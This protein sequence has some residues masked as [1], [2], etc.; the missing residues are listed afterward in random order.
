MSVNAGSR[1]FLLVIP[2]TGHVLF[3]DANRAIPP[4]A[5]VRLL[6]NVRLLVPGISVPNPGSQ[7]TQRCRPDL[8]TKVALTSA[9]AYSTVITGIN[10]AYRCAWSG[11][12][13]TTND[14]S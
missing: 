14:A 11:A 2:G 12:C 7:R 5:S 10:A 8:F 3:S 13:V 1:D 4:I 9:T 6:H